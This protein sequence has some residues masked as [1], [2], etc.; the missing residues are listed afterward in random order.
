MLN[1]HVRACP[2]AIRA[3]RAIRAGR[4]GRAGRAYS[5]AGGHTR[6]LPMYLASLETLSLGFHPCTTNQV[7]TGYFT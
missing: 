1:V 6:L 3:I 5:A 4:A 7:V 2:R